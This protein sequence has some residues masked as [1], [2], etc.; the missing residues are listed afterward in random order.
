MDNNKRWNRLMKI[1]KKSCA[2]INSSKTNGNNAI[3]INFTIEELYEI[4]SL[5]GNEAT[6]LRRK[7]LS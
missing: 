6:I 1:N 2:A 5:S 7:C 3:E 4:A